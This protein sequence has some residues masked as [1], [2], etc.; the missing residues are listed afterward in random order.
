[1]FSFHSSPFLLS[2]STPFSIPLE[3]LITCSSSSPHQIPPH[4][5]PTRTKKIGLSVVRIIRPF[6]IKHYILSSPLLLGY[7]LHPYYSLSFQMCMLLNHFTFLYFNC[8]FICL[9]MYLSSLRA[10]IF[11]KIVI[12]VIVID[13]LLPLYAFD[14]YQ[15]CVVFSGFQAPFRET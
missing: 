1:M 6:L 7:T 4:R 5:L 15:N 3:I 8:F 2:I 10:T 12:I 11:N 13:I 9:C 14:A